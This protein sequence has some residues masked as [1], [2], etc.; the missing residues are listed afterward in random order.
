VGHGLWVMGHGSR[1]MPWEGPQMLWDED[2]TY[3]PAGMG[4]GGPRGVPGS[5]QIGAR[6]PVDR[7]EHA[8]RSAPDPSQTLT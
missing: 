4:A 1:Q 5:F 6:A 7:G 8:L 2:S 3:H